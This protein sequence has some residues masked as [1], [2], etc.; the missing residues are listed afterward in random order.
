MP[1]PG[2]CAAH[3]STDVAGVSDWPSHYGMW[4][5]RQARLWLVALQSNELVQA[6]NDNWV[7]V[8]HKVDCVFP[9]STGSVLAEWFTGELEAGV[10]QPAHNRYAFKWPWLRVPHIDRG[11]VARSEL[12]DKRLACREW[13]A[14]GDKYRSMIESLSDGSDIEAPAY[15]KKKPDT[16]GA[17]GTPSG[18][19]GDAQRKR[20]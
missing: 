13:K 6:S 7:H 3:E 17:S 5:V 20:A 14:R 10:G 18:I 4:A 2:Y 11:V 16:R 8:E 1:R 9:G 19:P 15:L 12:R